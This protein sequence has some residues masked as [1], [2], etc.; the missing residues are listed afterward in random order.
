MMRLIDTKK[1]MSF[2]RIA[3]KYPDNQI[4]VKIVEIDHDKGRET[5]IVLCIGDTRKELVDYSK[6]NDILE[7]TIILEGVNLMPVLRGIL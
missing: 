2:V 1:E 5:G 7:D 6:S 3:E 4:L